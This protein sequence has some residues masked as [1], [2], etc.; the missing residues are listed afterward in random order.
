MKTV[1]DLLQDRDRH[2]TYADYKQFPDEIRVEIIDGVLYD[3]T[4]APVRRHQ[5]ISIRLERV[6]DPIALARGCE[7]YHAPFDIRLPQAEP[8]LVV[9]DDRRHPADDGNVSTVVQPDIVVVCDKSVL[10]DAGCSGPPELVIEILSPS[11]SY[12]DQ[13]KKLELYER[14]DVLEYWI[15]NPEAPWVMVYRRTAPGDAQF[16][17]PEYYRRDES[18]P[19][20]LLGGLAAGAVVELEAVFA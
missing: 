3:M 20:E 7:L 2:W 10:D 5:L 6:L 4:A 17:K 9:G 14:H 12:K 1:A 19:V 16:A 18:I 15:V 11:T 13:S 8:V